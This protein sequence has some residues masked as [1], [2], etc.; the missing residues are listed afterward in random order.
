[1]IMPELQTNVLYYGDNLEV[2]RDQIPNE[3]IDL[4]YLDPPFNSKQSY[5]VL[6]RESSGAAS[7]AQI[8]AF[9]DTWQWTI[10]G[11]APKA[12]DAIMT[13]PRQDVAS[14]LGAMVQGL[15]RNQV[16]SYLCMMTVR[17]VELHRVLKATGSLYLHCD[18]TAGAYLR[19]I[20][21][22]IFEP[23]NFRNEIIWKRTS[24]HND[25]RKYGANI[26]VIWY[27]VKSSK[28]T[29][30]DVF[31]EHREE[32]LKRFT[33]RDS[34]GRAW[35]DG[36]LT[37]K[38]LTGGGYTYEYKGIKGF[39]RCPLATMERY[40]KEGLLHITN[41][42]GIRIKRYLD[43]TEGVILQSL[44]TDIPP[45]NSQAK[46]RLG[47]N[48]QKPQ[49]L[50][51]RIVSV[52][53]NPGDIVLDPFCGCGTALHAAHKLD[54]K[55]I[56]IDVT[57]L[58]INLIERR[59]RDAFPGVPIHVDGAPADT[60]SAHDLARRDK[61]QFQWWALAKIDAQPVSG[62]KKKG[63]DKGKDGV[64]PVFMDAEISY[65]NAIVSVK[66]GADRDVSDIRDLNG[67]MLRENTPFGVLITL[68]PPT[69]P[70][71]TEAASAG[72]YESE[73]WG[74]K[75]PRIQ[76]LSVEEI[77]QGKRPNLP[78]GKSPYAKAPVEKTVNGNLNLD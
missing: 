68:F 11:Q 53:S 38:G 23:V 2:L 78:K 17:L 6:F 44:W 28:N 66:G 42:N 52:S 40:D 25:P 67:T 56:G 71:I 76:I 73:F 61:Y 20:L 22:A 21:D 31:T 30:N 65:R 74:R 41:R 49:A 19:V 69:K 58:A 63:A 33:H 70:M 27:Y 24:A 32:Y 64:I 35:Q 9:E 54:R 55:W 8:E 50:L 51:E 10:D 36:P 29:W 47:Y 13:G 43:E 45:V 60:A 59:M 39:W 4:I 48:T 37:A 18:P 14:L 72:L 1:M 34:D 7:E 12:Y 46:E 15:G 77:F 26:D 57:Y 5:S 75:F 3:S 62:K 16:T